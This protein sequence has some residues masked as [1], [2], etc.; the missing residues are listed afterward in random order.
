MIDAAG[1]LRQLG[2]TEY[3]ARAYLA[4]LQQPGATGYEVAKVSGVPRAKIYEVLG[5]LSTKNLIGGSEEENRTHY[6]PVD[7]DVVLRRHV[8]ST[9][10]TAAQLAPQLQRVVRSE[11]PPPLVTVRGYAN[12]MARAEDVAALAQR[13]L[14]VSGW[15]R[16][17]HTL[18]TA[19]DRAETRGVSVYAVS[20]GP[21]TL[22]ISGVYAHNPIDIDDAGFTRAAA[23]PW[24]IVV[25]DHREVLIGQPAPADQ[26]MALWTRNAA[27]ATVAAEYVKHDVYQL[28]LHRLLDERGINLNRELRHVQAMWFE[29][30]DKE[31]S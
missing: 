4:L 10:Q 9:R 6:H 15:P 26:S 3:E 13:R 25:A 8:E 12:V 19:L 11:Q 21:T 18:A 16:E 24:L 28:E 2:M 30:W 1:G 14:F 20:F 31:T 23:V 17:L 7:P 5:A 27:L 29:D 22:P